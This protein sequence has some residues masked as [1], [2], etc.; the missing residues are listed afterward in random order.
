MIP[1]SVVA[2]VHLLHLSGGMAM[3]SFDHSANGSSEDD[4]QT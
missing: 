3:T 2:V 1:Q 4:A